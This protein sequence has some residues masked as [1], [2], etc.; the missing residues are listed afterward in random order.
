M[1]VRFTLVALAVAVASCGSG[2]DEIGARSSAVA[3]CVHDPCATGSKLSS[4]CDP[5][6]T[7][8]CAQDGFCCSS[9]WDAQC[10][11]EVASICGQTC[12]S[13]GGGA[14][15][16]GGGGQKLKF[17]VFGDC[18]PP[19]LEDTKGYPSAIIGGIFTLAQSLGAQFVVGTGDYMF[20]DSAAAVDAQVQLFLQARAHY[21]GPVYL[22]MGNHECN[23]YT[24]SNCPNGDET[25]NVQAFLSKLAPAGVTAPYFRIDVPAAHGAAKL[26]FIA[27][28][29]WSSTQQS[30][31]QQQLAEPSAYTFVV[32]HE[33]A[34]DTSA[35]GVSPSESLIKAAAYTLELNGHTHEYKRVDTRHVISG[36]GGAPLHAGNFGLLLVEENDDGSISVTAYDEASGQPIDTW[37][38]T[39]G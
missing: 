3:A 16:G 38:V 20:A 22:D 13:G 8:I 15:G 7:D 6:V 37:T 29:A 31:L 18:R 2:S 11:A 9:S 10:V 27:A 21:S 32:R 26:L 24:S 30:W 19:I 4:G 1:I 23:G 28:N 12:G 14:G 33:P 39:A 25:P 36:N 17:A 34:K 5:C 35:P